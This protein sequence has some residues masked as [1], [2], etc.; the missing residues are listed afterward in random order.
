MRMVIT[1]EGGII[2]DI[3]ADNE[4]DILIVD[5]DTEGADTRDLT[6]VQQ[7]DG[8]FEDAYIIPMGADIQNDR[9]DYFFNHLLKED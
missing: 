7:Y 5:Y 2:Q 4:C 1:M 3:I 8:K 9:I 6:S